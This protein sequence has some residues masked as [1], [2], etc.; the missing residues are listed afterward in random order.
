MVTEKIENEVQRLKLDNSIGSLPLSLDILAT[1]SGK[2]FKA[3]L[4]VSTHLSS[5][6]LSKR[7]TAKTAGTA[8]ISGVPGTSSPI[9]IEAPL[10]GDILPTGNP[11]NYIEV[12][13]LTVRPY[14][15]CLKPNESFILH[16]T[17]SRSPLSMS[18]WPA[19]LF[20]RQVSLG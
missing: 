18:D 20:P 9:E 14:L 6:G 16:I 19:S 12:D 1:D 11:L 8:A 7:W 10:V 15:A 2:V 13:G 3:T 5:S 4:D 17:R